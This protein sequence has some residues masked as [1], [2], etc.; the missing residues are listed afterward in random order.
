MKYG[1]IAAGIL[2]ANLFTYPLSTSAAG[3][4][5]PDVPSWA[6]QSV[7]YLVEKH[8]LDGKPDGTFSP[9][10]EID[11]G[12]AAK[13]IAMVL[14]LQ[15][16][17]EAKPSFQDAKHHWAA[18]YI[19]AVEKAGVIK[20]DGSGH[21]NPSK[22]IDRAS[23]ASMLVEAYKLNNRIIGNLPTQFADL[24]G[25]WGEKQANTLVALGISK[26][27]GDG[28][29][30][31]GIVTRAEAAQFI[32]QTDMQK[33]D[34]S[35]R[36]YM[37]RYFITYHQPSLSSGIT[38]NQHAPQMVVVKE[39]REDGWLKIVTDKGDK[40]TPLQ[41]KKEAIHSA[42]TTYQ[43]ASH[44]SEILGTYAPQTVTVIEESGSWIRIRTSSG[45]QWVDKNQLNPPKQD[46]FLEGKAIIID[47]GHGGIDPGHTGVNMDESKIVLDTAL[48]V[49]KLFEQKTPFTVLLTHDTDVRPGTDAKDSLRERVEFAQQNNGDIFVS[50]HGN[51]FDGTAHGTETYYYRSATRATNPYVDDSRLLAEKIQSRLVDALGT[52]DRGVKE[53]DLY[54]VRENTM[55]AV[56]TELG[57]VDNQIEG[58]KLSSPEW[59]QRAAEAIYAGILDYYQAKGH[60]VSAYR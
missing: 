33:A 27:T 34:T 29:K 47:P 36:M 8:A 48:R 9:S 40:W 25:H 19:A 7:N 6:Q 60:N 5:F 10:E 1:V 55:P 30:P 57:F 16:N 13:L 14:G 42:F 32:A 3:K 24:K 31:N 44:S 59:R 22:N 56:L 11:R 26:G 41:E 54:V 43:E 15:I 46:N 23:M 50:I 38:S 4:T 12:S 37:N 49:Q 51:G 17:K 18:P 58:E 28:W 53:G 52:R 45:F 20:G 35:K 2:A 21:F 39:E